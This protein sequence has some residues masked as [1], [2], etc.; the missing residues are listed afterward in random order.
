MIIICFYVVK[1]VLLISLFSIDHMSMG[2][3][4]DSFYEYLLKVWLQTNKE[5]NEAR[6]MFDDAMQAVFQHMLK[7]SQNGLMY[8]ADLKFD[9]VEHKMDHLACFSG[10]VNVIISI[11]YAKEIFIIYI[12]LLLNHQI[13]KEKVQ[14]KKFVVVSYIFHVIYSTLFSLTI[15]SLMC[16]HS[17]NISSF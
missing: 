15:V 17:Q 10:N 16:L 11:Y 12:Y 3:L 13:P 9:R 14:T 1:N 4:G 5:D 6:Q 8:F 2:A 7:T